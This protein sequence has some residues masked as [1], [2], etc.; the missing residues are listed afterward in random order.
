[1]SD[2]TESVSNQDE[3][4]EAFPSLSDADLALF[5]TMIENGIFKPVYEHQ[6]A[7]QDNA[8]LCFENSVELVAPSKGGS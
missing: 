6:T 2:A 7:V 1:M 4:R 5:T 8:A 3:P